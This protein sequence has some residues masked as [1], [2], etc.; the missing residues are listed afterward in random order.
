MLQLDPHSLPV[1]F[2]ARDGRADGGVRRIEINRDRVTVRRAVGGMRMAINVAVRDFL[3]ITCRDTHEGKALV[4]V[5]RD[6][7]LS[8]P[9][10]VTSDDVQIERAWQIWSDLFALPQIEDESGDTREPALRRRSRNVIK[11]RRP[12]FLVRRKA[13]RPAMEQSIHRGE[14]EIIARH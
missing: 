7:S 14:R 10:L 6:P 3:G 9:L 12:R 2:E 13:G 8:V 11:T 5:H 1:S 4:L